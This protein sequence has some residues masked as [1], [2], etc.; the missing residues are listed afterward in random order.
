MWA[1]RVAQLV[2]EL[3]WAWQWRAVW[4]LVWAWQWRVGQLA[5]AWAWQ[6]GVAQSALTWAWRLRALLWD[7]GGRRRSSCC[8]ESRSA[9]IRRRTTHRWL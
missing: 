1:P 9:G 4:A 8:W 6:S 3:S 7:W 5:P 2:L